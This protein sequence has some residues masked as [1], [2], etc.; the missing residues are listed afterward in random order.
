MKKAMLVILAM[1]VCSL[2]FSMDSWA[3]RDSASLDTNSALISD[4]SEAQSETPLG[5]VA[6]WLH[7]NLPS[8]GKWVECDGRTLNAAQYSEYVAQFGTKVPDLRDSMLV[9]K[10]AN[11]TAGSTVAND[12]FVYGSVNWSGGDVYGDFSMQSGTMNFSSF[13]MDGTYRGT[14]VSEGAG[15]NQNKIQIKPPLHSPYSDE[16]PIPSYTYTLPNN[17]KGGSYT[18]PNQ[19]GIRVPETYPTGYNRHFINISN[20]SYKV[21]SLMGTSQKVKTKYIIK[22]KM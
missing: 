12:A 13:Y 8:D 6:P 17:P 14:T 2:F 18:I 15:G 4:I 9:G 1:L 19:S 3:V 16:S 7:S 10:K 21:H 5:M 22:V 11:E 20:G